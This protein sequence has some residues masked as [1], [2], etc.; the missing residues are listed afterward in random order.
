M[1]RKQAS[2]KLPKA[3]YSSL[4]FNLSFLG[5]VKFHTIVF[6][7][8]LQLVIFVSVEMRDRGVLVRAD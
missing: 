2:A 1:R 8:Y 7:F 5:A 6:P 3:G 4:S